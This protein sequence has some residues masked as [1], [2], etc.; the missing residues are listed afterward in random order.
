MKVR[1]NVTQ[2][3]QLNDISVKVG[4]V[5]VLQE[6]GAKNINDLT[7]TVQRLVEKFEVNNDISREA[8]DKAKS[9]HH[10]LDG[11]DKIIFWGGTTII[12]AIIL[13]AI[14][15]VVSGGFAN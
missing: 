14:A 3:Q 13:S 11:I 7:V 6:V 1:C 15:F 12:G 4:R 10:R 5:E 9:A 8:L 2:E